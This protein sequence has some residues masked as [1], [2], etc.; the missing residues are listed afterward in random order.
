MSKQANM[1]PTANR[2]KANDPDQGLSNKQNMC[3]FEE[4]K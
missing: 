3:T 2:L 1:A 4:L